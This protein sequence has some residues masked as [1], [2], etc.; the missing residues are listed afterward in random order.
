MTVFL[1]FRIPAV[2]APAMGLGLGFQTAS[3]GRPFIFFKQKKAGILKR[4][5]A[6]QHLL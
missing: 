1:I 5:P 4:L 6:P 3:V 2:E